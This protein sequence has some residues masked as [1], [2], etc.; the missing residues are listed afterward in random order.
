MRSLLKQFKLALKMSGFFLVVWP[1]AAWG[2]A[3]S[4]PSSTSVTLTGP[5]TFTYGSVAIAAGGTLKI[6]GQVFLNVTGSVD[7]EG[8]IYGAG[9]GYPGGVGYSV[10]PGEGGNTPFD[11]Q[12]AGGG[13]HG[14]AG[15]AGYGANASGGMGGLTTDNP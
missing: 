11:V 5:A 15:G 8:T 7:V 12:G 10:N 6:V 1:M 14:G 3:L 13:G 2:Q 4:I 9:N